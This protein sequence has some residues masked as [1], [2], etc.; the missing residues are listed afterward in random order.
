[1]SIGHPYMKGTQDHE[2]YEIEEERRRREKHEESLRFHLDQQ[3][4]H[5]RQMAAQEEQ[6]LRDA[7][8]QRQKAAEQRQQRE[9]D[10]ERRAAQKQAAKKARTTGKKSS[11]DSEWN[12]TAAILAF[13]FSV[14]AAHSQLGWDGPGLWI[15]S[16]FAALMA[17]AYYKQILG[18]GLIAMVLYAV[19]ASQ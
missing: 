16:G 18:F 7:E 9:L 5:R 15:A 10:K 17:G 11:N 6:R 19:V 1:M 12:W 2:N 4:R 8:R 13:I 3:E 14:G